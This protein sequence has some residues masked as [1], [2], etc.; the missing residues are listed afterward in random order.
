MYGHLAKHSRCCAP[1]KM[2]LKPEGGGWGEGTVDWT[3]TGHLGEAPLF[4]KWE[5][6]QFLFLSMYILDPK[7]LKFF[8]AFHLHI[9]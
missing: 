1:I 3:D 6:F 7:E 5:I 8:F 4:S 9:L 2:Y